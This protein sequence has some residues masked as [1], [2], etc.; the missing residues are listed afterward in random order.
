MGSRLIQLKGR[1]GWYLEIDKPLWLRRLKGGGNSVKR[2]AGDSRTEASRNALAIESEVL[3]G[4]DELKEADPLAAAPTRS[5]LSGE[6]LPDATDALMREAGWSMMR[7]EGIGC[8][9]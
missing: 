3:K 8:N 7:A 2:K 9:T 1:K 5:K 6:S 4:W